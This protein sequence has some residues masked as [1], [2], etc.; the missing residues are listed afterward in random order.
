[1]ITSLD[2]LDPDGTYTLAN[3]VSWQFDEMVELIDRRLFVKPE[4]NLLI[5]QDVAGRLYAQPGNAVI[6]ANGSYYPGPVDVDLSKFMGKTT[7]LQPDAVVLCD[8]SKKTRNRIK[9]A[10]D[11]V[12]EVISKSSIKRDTVTKF[13]IYEQA[14]IKEYFIIFHQ[15]R[16]LTNTSWLMANTK[17][18]ASLTRAQYPQRLWPPWC[19]TATACL[20][21]YL[22][23]AETEG[24]SRIYSFT[25]RA[26]C[27]F[28][29][30]R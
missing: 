27:P 25:Q 13:A 1:M 29:R 11:I 26:L 21:T 30:S 4:A 19:L 5:H 22:A 20:A 18:Q 6:V 15:S 2:Q 28:S 16:L 8:A 10:P 14:G 3:Y 24:R 23:V 12:F 7:M 9:G 17:T